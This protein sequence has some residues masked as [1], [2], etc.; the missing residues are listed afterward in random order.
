MARNRS[1]QQRRRKT[2]ARRVLRQHFIEQMHKATTEEQWNELFN[3]WPQEAKWF[4]KYD[5]KRLPQPLVEYIDRVKIQAAA[6][7]NL[8]TPQQGS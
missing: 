7:G 1:P 3:K 4:V 5:H 8:K 2:T 6:E